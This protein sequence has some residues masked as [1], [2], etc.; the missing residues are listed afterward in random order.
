MA[1]SDNSARYTQKTVCTNNRG[2]SVDRS[3]D[4]RQDLKVHTKLHHHRRCVIMGTGFSD[5]AYE[6][7]L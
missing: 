6:Y 3:E 4:M 5:C 1:A 2:F 7:G